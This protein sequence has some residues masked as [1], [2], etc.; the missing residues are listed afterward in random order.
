MMISNPQIR[1]F[2][3]FQTLNFKNDEYQA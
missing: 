2:N 1:H 3:L